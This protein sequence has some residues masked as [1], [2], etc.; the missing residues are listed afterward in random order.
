M[1]KVPYGAELDSTQRMA[2][3]H[4]TGHAERLIALGWPVDE[5][6]VAELH[7]LSRDPVVYGIAL[8]TELGAME[9]APEVWGHRQPLADL[10]RKCGADLEVAERQRAW[11]VAQR[12]TT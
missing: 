9:V 11:R 5:R 10:Y 8:G 1:G 2:I 3:A 4:V 12:W 6:A 7:T